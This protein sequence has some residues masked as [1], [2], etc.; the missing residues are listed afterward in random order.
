MALL[1]INRKLNQTYIAIEESIKMF[2]KILIPL[3][4]SELAER[5]LEP[6]LALAEKANSQVIFLSVPVPNHFVRQHNGIGVLYPLQALEK[7]HQET[8]EYLDALKKG[9]ARKGYSLNVIIHDGDPA[10]VIVDTAVAEKAD[11]IVMS[12][13]GRSGFSRWMIG[14]V[15]T[16]VLRQAPCPVLVIRSSKLISRILIPL[17]GSGLAEQALEPGFEIA[18]GLEA[19]VLLL[20]VQESMEVSSLEIAQFEKAEKGL[21]VRVEQSV[22]ERDESYLETLAQYYE[23]ALEV[24]TQYAVADGPVSHCILDAA[25]NWNADLIIMATHGRTGLQRWVYGSV[26]E[27][28]LRGANCSLLI[29]R[30]TAHSLN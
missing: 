7:A 12:T 4:G 17:D 3:D 2:E 6:A 23:K 25:D 13:H 18:S 9:K 21:G 16:K 22:Y 1:E 29:I 5:A 20:T 15:T 24:H 28:I 19:E 26:T 14:S 30:P 10:S 8:N 27:K 11:L